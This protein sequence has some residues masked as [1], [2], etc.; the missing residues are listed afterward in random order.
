MSVIETKDPVCGMDVEPDQAAGKSEFN[1]TAYYF[2]SQ[3]CKQAFDRSPE[4]YARRKTA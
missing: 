3:Q 4:Q 2:C 1:G